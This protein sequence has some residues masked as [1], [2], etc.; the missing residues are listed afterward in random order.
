MGSSPYRS[1][2]AFYKQA[3]CATFFSDVS[4]YNLYKG[5]D[6]SWISFPNTP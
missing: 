1:T 3:N 2:Q 5:Q 4:V 6:W